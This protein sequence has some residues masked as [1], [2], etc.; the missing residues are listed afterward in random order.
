MKIGN[1]YKKSLNK[2]RL[3]KLLKSLLEHTRASQ[4]PKEMHRIFSGLC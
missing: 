4:P 3:I 1:Y 2:M